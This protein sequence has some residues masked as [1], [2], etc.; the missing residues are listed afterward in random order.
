MDNSWSIFTD[1]L[2][3]EPIVP[4]MSTLPSSL[5]KDW[6]DPPFFTQNV[7]KVPERKLSFDTPQQQ[8]YAPY[9]IPES[10]PS[11][12]YQMSFASQSFASQAAQ[13]EPIVPQQ[14]ET[15]MYATVSFRPTRN[16]I[17]KYKSSLNLKPGDYV[18][19]EA[20]RG[21]DIGTVSSVSNRANAREA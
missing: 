10:A 9:V 3:D 20:D 17:Y 5:N 15:T 4:R 14:P 11:A 19:T 21:F 8:P 6:A 1:D 13:Q 16:E 7:S 18:I 12:N 2:E